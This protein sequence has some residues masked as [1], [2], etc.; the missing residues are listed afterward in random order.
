MTEL[1][2]VSRENGQPSAEV[3]AAFEA[4]GVTFGAFMA[5]VSVANDA[6]IDVAAA[7]GQSL[8][9]SMSAD[10]LDGV[11]VYLRMALGL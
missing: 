10:E 9:G 11:P 5:A 3:Q 4:L 2:A 7:I 6:G 8:R 1:A